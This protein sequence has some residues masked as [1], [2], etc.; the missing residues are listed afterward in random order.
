MKHE[1]MYNLYKL[2]QSKHTFCHRSGHDLN[3]F[4][5]LLKQT[6]IVPQSYATQ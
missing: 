2:I 5:E 4:P 3:S 6:V 1:I